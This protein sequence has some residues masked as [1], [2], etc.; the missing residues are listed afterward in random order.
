MT[1]EEQKILNESLSKLFKLDQEKIASLYNEAGD[2]I[3]FSVVMDADEERVSR[4]TKD[5]DSQYKRGIKEGAE[6]IENAVKEK[7]E[8]ESDSVGVDLID[9]IVVKK[10]EEAKL[11]GTK[12]ITKHPEYQKL[13][14]SVE[15]KL[16][17]RDKEWQAKLD[18][19]DLE[20]AQVK[21]FEKVS[22]KALVNV[23]TRNPILP[24]DPRV[25][26]KREELFLNEL[27]TGKYRED[28]GETIIVLDNDGN[29]LKDSHGHPISFDD[30][31]KEISDV[32]YEFSK[33]E[34]RSSA[35]NKDDKGTGGSNG[36]DP[37]MTEEEYMTRLRNPKITPKERIELTNF[38]TSKQ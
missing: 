3:N 1:K 26:Q 33:S 34:S 15:K 19:K 14:L 6:K 2:L 31:V 11:S 13:E 16:K 38:W 17:D 23:K 12:D 30:Y 20:F 10:I 4:F 27:K 7:Y 24:T 25:I 9:Q 37:K 32:H 8:F 5:K 21:L 36:F 28:E 29:V 35:G 18:L 22:K